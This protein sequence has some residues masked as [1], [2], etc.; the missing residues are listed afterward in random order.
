MSRDVDQSD[1]P[2]LQDEEELVT[3]FK[4]SEKSPEYFRVGAETER[5]LFAKDTLAP[6]PY[7]GGIRPLLEG[8][9]QKG[10][11]MEPLGLHKD[12][13]SVS[14]EPGGQLELAGRPVT[15]SDDTRAEVDTFNREIL[16][17]CEPLGIGVSSLGMRPFSRVSDACWMPRERY[18]GMR[19]YLDAQGQCGHHMMVMT[20][21][22]QANYDFES[23]ADMVRK[24]RVGMGASPIVAA[25]F[26]NSPYGPDGWTGYRSRRCAIWFHVDPERCGLLP[27]VYE[28]DFG[29]RKYLDYILDIPMFFLQRGAVFHDVERLTFR[30]FLHEGFNGEKAT[31]ADFETHLSTIFPEVRLK[32]FIE[33][34]SA[35]GGPAEM[36]AALAALWKGLFYDPTSLA[37]A[38]ALLK[39]FSM[40]QRLQMQQCAAQ[41]AL[42]GHGKGFH[43]GE[44]AKELVKLG[45]EGL[46]RLS[47]G[48]GDESHHLAPLED[49]ANSG[50]TLADKL[51]AKFGAGP[52]DEKARRSIMQ[53]TSIDAAS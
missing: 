4:A 48:V 20:A 10:W 8:M 33:V 41:D 42:K 14:L 18:R 39:D 25:L 37:A 29:F 52:L 26:A 43:M 6:I 46:K 38:D 53:E 24:M 17:V 19:T 21:T 47:V 22:I 27:M 13:M 32:R 36:A 12:G 2:I 40:P 50:E 16:D 7:E 23:E 15:H 1:T 11:S 30:K 44:L 28:E 9:T 51:L 5:V 34:R 31:L 49:I 3:F 35:D 45:S